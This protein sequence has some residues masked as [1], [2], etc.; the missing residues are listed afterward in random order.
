MAY[1]VIEFWSTPERVKL[2]LDELYTNRFDKVILYGPHEWAYWEG[3]YWKDLDKA[4]YETNHELVMITG[5]VE[6]YT[7]KRPT[8][9][10]KSTLISWPTHFFPR[11]YIHFKPLKE[12]LPVVD[13]YRYHFISMNYQPRY[14]RSM[15]MDLVAKNKLIHWAAISWHRLDGDAY[16]WRYWKPRLMQLSDRSFTQSKNQNILPEEYHQSF[17]QLVSETC[18]DALF[19]SEKTAVPLFMCKPFLVASCQNFHAFIE[20][21][22][23]KLY[24]EIFDYSFDTEP[25]MEKRFE[26]LLENF[27]RLTK[28]P[29]SELPKLKEKVQE[30]LDY[31]KQLAYDI[32]FD[33]NLYPAVV[34]ELVDIYKKDGTVMN[35]ILVDMYQKVFETK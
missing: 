4:C 2:K 35:G 15:L 27:K 23:F 13:E 25:N 32:V 19:L 21:L 11:T 16:T 20:S 33:Y 30:K 17:A 14:A 12:S 8:P 10:S 29:L 9:Q 22:G 6:Y 5:S 7:D 24:D 1:Q 3:P 31:N 34:K 18:V 28:L 26:M